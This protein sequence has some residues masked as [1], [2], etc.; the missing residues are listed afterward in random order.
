MSKTL[1]RRQ[2]IRSPSVLLQLN[3]VPFSGA[4]QYFVM[5]LSCPDEVKEAP[6]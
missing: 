1:Y 5:R 4:G 6:D 3:W 2:K